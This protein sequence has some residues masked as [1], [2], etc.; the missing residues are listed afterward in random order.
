MEKI[1][2]NQLKKICEAAIMVS[3]RALSIK[4]LLALFEEI[5]RPSADDLKEALTQL[6]ADYAERAVE[7]KEVA[8]GFRFQARSEYSP[9]LSRLWE[10]RPAKYSRSF[11]ETLVL[12]AYR[13]PITRGEIEEI[14]G[15]AVNTNVI[16]ALIERE[17]I[18]EVG[19]KEVPGH[20]ALLATTKHFLDYFNLKSLDDLPT[21]D[22]IKDLD[23][24]GQQFELQISDENLVQLETAAASSDMQEKN[25]VTLEEAETADV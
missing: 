13:Q 15:V 6:Q 23:Q 25:L 24:I 10:E 21:L 22:E 4:D 1:E 5:D 16:K 20:P 18:R 3:D 17:W 19:H 9:W 11:L 14:R 2:I 8:T 12:V 7:L